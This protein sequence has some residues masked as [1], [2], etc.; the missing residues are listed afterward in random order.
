MESEIVI[1]MTIEALDEL[2]TEISNFSP[3]KLKFCGENSNF[4]NPGC[5]QKQP[6]FR[7]VKIAEKTRVSGCGLTRVKNPT[8]AKVHLADLDF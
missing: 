1:G 8:I 7:V 6:G 4:F 5:R 2:D 3:Q